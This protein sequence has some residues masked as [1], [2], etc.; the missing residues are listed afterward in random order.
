MPITVSETKKEPPKQENEVLSFALRYLE[1]GFS[2]IPVRGKYYSG[3]NESLSKSPLI[4]WS[5]F[6]HRHPTEEEVRLWF[7]R[8]PHANIAVITGAISGIVV[9]DF[10]SE[11][12]VRWAKQEG[13]LN[14][15][16]VKTA[17]GLHAYYSHPGGQLQN[18]TY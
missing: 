16:L 11:E 15:P 3:G 6:Q 4:K 14:T 13:L 12:A 10:D 18:V 7:S 9:V 8:Y 17:R 1:L 5:E 2:I